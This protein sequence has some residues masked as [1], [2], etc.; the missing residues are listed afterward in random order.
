VFRY[1]SRIFGFD[2]LRESLMARHASL[3]FLLNVFSL[4]V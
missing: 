1:S 4:P 2:H 3:S